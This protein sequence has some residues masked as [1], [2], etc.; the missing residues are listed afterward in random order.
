M[1]AG[2]N[3]LNSVESAFEGSGAIDLALFFLTRNQAYMLP[4]DSI[5]MLIHGDAS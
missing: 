2:Q 1:R 5:Y 3:S 4:K